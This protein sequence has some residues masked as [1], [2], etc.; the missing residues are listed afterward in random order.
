MDE[1]HIQAY[2]GPFVQTFRTQYFFWDIV[3]LTKRALFVITAAFIPAHPGDSTL[4]FACIFIVFVYLALEFF[5]RPFKNDSVAKRSATW[6]LLAVLILLSDSLVFKSS[7][8]S[9]RVKNAFSILMIV[10]V[11][12]VLCLTIHQLIQ[13]FRR[14]KPKIID[15]NLEELPADLQV[16]TDPEILAKIINFA[17]LEKLTS[18]GIHSVTLQPKKLSIAPQMDIGRPSGAS[19]D[20]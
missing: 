4:Y 7:G 20:F 2:F 10:L 17:E 11:L 1:P 16:C 14:G 12:M 18:K 9:D 13:R 5:F 19:V 3:I 8:A 6:S 15:L